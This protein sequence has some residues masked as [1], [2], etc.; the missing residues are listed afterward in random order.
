MADAPRW[1]GGQQPQDM[2]P[3]RTCPVSYRYAPSTLARSAEIE[4]D[5]LYVTG[6]VYGNAY[7]LERIL[8][9]VHEERDGAALVFNGDFN[10]FNVNACDFA[11]TNGVGTRHLALRGNVETEIAHDDPRAGCGCAYPDGV[12][13]DEVERSNAMIVR[14]RETARG[15]PSVRKQLSALPMH[16]VAQIAGIRVGIVHGDAESLAGWAYSESAL[17]RPDGIQRLR[18]HIAAA[19]VRVLASSHTCLPVALGFETA[20]GPCALF[21]N[22]AA[23]MPNFRGTQHGLITRIGTRPSARA[24]YGVRIGGAH[25]EALA[26]EYDHARWIDAFQASWPAGSAAHRSYFARLA[27][28]PPY[29]FSAAVRGTVSWNVDPRRNGVGRSTQ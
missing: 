1:A 7:A 21:N 24:L 3:G 12:S 23:G 15:F 26:V 5:T 9:L 19:R 22:G 17:A 4:A 16:L 27:E 28:G 8:E 18:F 2:Q 13:D 25:V 14:L 29:G 6:G 11:A 10:W 20:E